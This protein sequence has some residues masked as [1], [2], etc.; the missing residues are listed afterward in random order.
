[1]VD[2][3]KF[4]KTKVEPEVLSDTES[5][6]EPVKE[7]EAKAESS[8]NSISDTFALCPNIGTIKFDKR[9]DLWMSSNSIIYVVE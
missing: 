7:K 3:S 9:F 5:D 4:P 2:D 8:N 1:M 6:I